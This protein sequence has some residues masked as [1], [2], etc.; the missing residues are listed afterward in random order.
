MHPTS[1]LSIKFQVL[2]YQT[3]YRITD[4]EDWTLQK[5][6]FNFK[7]FERERKWNKKDINF[8]NSFFIQKRK[9]FHLMLMLKKAETGIRMKYHK[10]NRIAEE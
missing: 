4:T 3:K 6:K 8:K 5:E 1:W 7:V 9:R 2:H 10:L